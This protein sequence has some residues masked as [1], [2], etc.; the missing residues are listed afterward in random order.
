M[1]TPSVL[2]LPPEEMRVLVG[3]VEPE[4]FD[5]PA[6]TLVFAGLE[7][8]RY[9]SVLDFGC[10]CGRIARQLIQ[11]RPRPHRY[12][13]VD[14]HPGM[15]R[16]C[17]E[18]LTPH[19]PSFE[20]RHHD[21]FYPRFNAAEGRPLHA[22]FSYADDEFS[23][24]IALSVFTHLTQ[25]Q[26]EAYLAELARVLEPGGVLVSTWFLF[27]K[28]DYPMMQDEQNTLFIN[29]YDVR[30]AVIYDREW[31]RATARNTGL[32]IYE[33]TAPSIR[34]F[35]WELRM[36]QPSPTVN[37]VTLPPDDADPGRNAPP[38]MPPLAH[39]IGLDDA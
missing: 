29:E 24:A 2:P 22:S 32:V 1:I 25:A 30:N 20:F 6:G 23:L 12:A 34:G 35:Q 38:P 3:P 13:G 36:T 8:D 21:V 7:V 26:A 37:E 33:A 18:N 27:D 19:A 4:L 10:G 9:R 39:R 28:L 16:W 31:M 17:S 15:I 11:Q 14:L 5:N